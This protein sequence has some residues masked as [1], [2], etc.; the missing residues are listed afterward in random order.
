MAFLED[1]CAEFWAALLPI[2]VVKMDVPDYW[3]SCCKIDGRIYWMTWSLIML[4]WHNGVSGYWHRN[5]MCLFMMCDSWLHFDCEELGLRVDK[6]PLLDCVRDCDV[7][8]M[9]T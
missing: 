1:D 2:R 5:L 4:L 6:L 9:A 7:R 3:A 8:V